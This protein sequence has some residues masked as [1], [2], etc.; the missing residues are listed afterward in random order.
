MEDESRGLRGAEL[1]VGRQIGLMHLVC[2]V[3]DGDNVYE[4]YWTNYRG[5]ESNG[6]QRRAHGPHRLRAP[7]AV[8]GLTDRMAATLDTRHPLMAD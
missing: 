2:Y 6:L 5:V 3:R 7:R 8:G 1:L 4:T